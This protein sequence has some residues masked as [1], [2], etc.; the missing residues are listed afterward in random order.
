MGHVLTK[1][2]RESLTM[3]TP[4][5]TKLFNECITEYFK[6]GFITNVALET[7]LKLGF[8][9]KTD[10]ELESEKPIVF[11]NKE[12]TT[13]QKGPYKTYDFSKEGSESNQRKSFWLLINDISNSLNIEFKRKN[14][15]FNKINL[16]IPNCILDII[17]S[18]VSIIEGNEPSKKFN[19][20]SASYYGF[21]K[22]SAF[23]IFTH[24]IDEETIYIEL[25]GA[26]EYVK[27]NII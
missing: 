16:I 9:E 10:S 24:E 15:T 22:Q 26:D 20:I 2:G 6:T 14:V 23:R 7:F 19:G 1:K 8:L 25:E 4:D 3:S 12:D 11:D 17:K 5:D 13:Q 21:L 18:S 27:V